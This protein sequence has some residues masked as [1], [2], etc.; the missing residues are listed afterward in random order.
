M[1]IINS[2]FSFIRWLAVVIKE[3]HE[4]RRDRISI[5][6]VFMT[7]LAQ[8]IILGYAVNMDPHRLPSA[9]LNYDTGPLSQVFVSSAQ[10][11]DYFNFHL[12]PSPEEARQAFVRGDIMFILTIPEGFTRQVLRGE[13]PRI[14]VQGDAVDPLAINNAL[15]ALTGATKT[16]FRNDLPEVLRAEEGAGEFE[17]VIHRMFNPEG[18]TQYNTVPGIIGSV[19]STTLI[20]MT[21]L[22]VTRERENGGMESLLISPVTGM[23]VIL[24]KIT[25]YVIIGGFQSVMILLSALFLFKIPMLG[26]VFLL[27]VVLIIFIFLCLAIGVTISGIAKN[28][29]QA[30]QLSSFYFIPSVMLSGFISPFISMPVWAQWIGACLPLTWFIRLIKGVMLKGYTASELM[31]ELLA[32]ASLAMIT[33]FIAAISYRKTLD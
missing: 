16:M 1:Q 8:L 14:L 31:P 13:K 27:F 6:M 28:Q 9:L 22:A 4:L 20:L 21:A 32:L 24:G 17:L 30:L 25:P 12:F 11:T 23:E 29:L 10:N 19:L 5:L 3:L 26:S 7:P 15:S 2:K 33:L 18:I